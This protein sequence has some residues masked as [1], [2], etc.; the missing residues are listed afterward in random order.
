MNIEYENLKTSNSIFSKEFKTIFEEFLDSGLYILGKNVKN[1]EDE[2]SQF[3]NVSN[4]IGVASG[5]DA[6]ILALKVLDLPNKSEIIVPSNTYIASILA[7]LHNGMKPVL[8]EPD[9]NSYN[10]D[11]LKIE[12]KITS[13]T[14]AI[15]PV[16][17][18]G[19][20]CEMDPI[21]DLANKYDLHIIEDCAQ[22][23]GAEYKGEKAGSFGIGCFSFYPTKNL[24]ALGD[25]GAITTGDKEYYKQLKALRNYGSKEKYYNERIGYNS[26]LDEIQACFLSVKLKF[27]NKLIAHKRNLA[28]LY[29]HNLSDKFITPQIQEGFFDVYHIF[30]VRVKE[31][32][33]LKDY[34]SN[35]G[36][37]TAIHYPISPH[38]QGALSSVIKGDFPISEEIHSSTL[39]LPISY[40]NT[41]EEIL[42]VCEVMNEWSA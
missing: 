3:C 37:A 16:H 9:I 40:S 15:M 11:P 32:N 17:L 33:A 13:K 36:I 29:F 31:R 23:H 2:F 19:K 12:E 35:K 27:L 20:C 30:N 34:L 7:V 21:I 6:L 10:I 5:L 1:F 39:S 8:V 25:A 4:C 38:K 26:R 28:N 42:N 14:K 22:A 18:Y 24:G 41:E